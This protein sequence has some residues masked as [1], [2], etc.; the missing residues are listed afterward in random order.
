ME[1]SCEKYSEVLE[2]QWKKRTICPLVH[3]VHGGRGMSETRSFP[4]LGYL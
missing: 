4:L 1:W 3:E 2:K